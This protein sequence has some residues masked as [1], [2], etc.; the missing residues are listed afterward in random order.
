MD[1][2][3][4]ARLIKS[5]KRVHSIIMFGSSARGESTEESDIDICIIEDPDFEFELS[6]KLKIMRNIPEKF[7][8][9]FFHDLPLNIRQRVLQEGEIL[10]TKDD[11][12]LFTLIKEIDFEMVKYRRM[13]DEYHREA[14]KRVK[15]RVEARRS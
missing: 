13:M 4:V 2:Q 7:D 11:Y 8:I 15:K 14:M 12:Y 9:S 1:V 5:H 10:Y 3:D 6:E